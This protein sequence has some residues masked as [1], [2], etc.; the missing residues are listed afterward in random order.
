MP[1]SAKSIRRCS[2]KK[3]P[4]KMILIA[5]TRLQQLQE[6]LLRSAT[7]PLLRW[8]WRSPALQLLNTSTCAS[9][10]HTIH[11]WTM[12]HPFLAICMQDISPI[13]IR[14]IGAE[15]NAPGAVSTGQIC[16]HQTTSPCHIQQANRWAQLGISGSTILRRSHTLIP[17]S[18]LKSLT[19]PGSCGQILN[20]TPL[21]QPA[22]S[23]TPATSASIGN[24]RPRLP[25]SVSCPKGRLAVSTPAE[26]GAEPMSP[27]FDQVCDA[28]EMPV[29]P[30]CSAESTVPKPVQDNFVEDVQSS[31]GE[32]RSALVQ[33]L[34][35]CGQPED[36]ERLPSMEEML[37]RFCEPELGFRKVG[38]GML[39]EAYRCGHVVFKV[40]TVF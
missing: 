4:P 13:P 15:N 23:A 14:K 8:P 2:G 39:G 40:S 1:T 24:S 25:Q 29:S 20:F 36:Q 19:T 37:A 28:L 11:F 34:S 6:M 31:P 10:A 16:Q 26:V 5:S 18:K 9:H 21:Q 32:K 12:T 35:F 7:F 38:E 27:S 30:C 3:A 17:T 33:L 22:L